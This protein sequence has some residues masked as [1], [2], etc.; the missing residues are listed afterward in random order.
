MHHARTGTT[1]TEA[2]FLAAAAR[3][4][5]VDPVAAV[6]ETLRLVLEEMRRSG[7]PSALRFTAALT[8]WDLGV[9][10]GERCGASDAVRSATSVLLPGL[11]RKLPNVVL[12]G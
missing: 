7:V 12:S 3:G 9:P 11:S 8:D 4:I 5:D 6:S 10:L 2:I 1:D